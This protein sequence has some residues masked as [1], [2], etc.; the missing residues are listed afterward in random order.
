MM[1]E[2][3]AVASHKPFG[4]VFAVE[5]NKYSTRKAP[6]IVAAGKAVD[7]FSKCRSTVEPSKKPSQFFFARVLKTKIYY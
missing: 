6:F 2:V 1:L 4:I 5:S 3:I 7:A